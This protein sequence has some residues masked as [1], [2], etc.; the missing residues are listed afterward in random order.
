MEFSPDR[1]PCCKPLN[2]LFI[3]AQHG[4]AL[5]DCR[6]LAARNSMLC[7][8]RDWGTASLI[9]ASAPNAWDFDSGS[10]SDVLAMWH[11]LGL[12]MHWRLPFVLQS[13]LAVQGRL[14]G[15]DSNDRVIIPCHVYFGRS[16][17]GVDGRHRRSSSS[18]PFQQPPGRSPPPTPR[19]GHNPQR[20][21]TRLD[22]PGSSR[23]LASGGKDRKSV[24]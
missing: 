6:Q 19:R 14:L 8:G 23:S 17:K 9:G 16:T 2:C 7:D 5:H 18:M 12:V 20:S 4:M 13:H 15:D 24:V 22:R 1:K 21:A 10:C 11:H 3:P